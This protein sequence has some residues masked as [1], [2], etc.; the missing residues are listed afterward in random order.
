MI[1]LFNLHNVNSTGDMYII[2]SRYDRINF[3]PLLLIRD[4]FIGSIVL[5]IYNV[6]VYYYSDL[7]GHCDNYVPAN[8]LV[9]PSEIMPE[10]YLLP[11]YALI[12]AI[13][14][15]VLG[16]IMMVLFLVCLTNLSPIVSV[17]SYPNINML[18]QSLL[19]ILLLDL[20][21]ASE[22]CLYINHY[23]CMYLLLILSIL[24]LLQHHI[25][26]SNNNVSTY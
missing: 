5:I 10:F 17:R 1:H 26:I 25:F 15:K 9:T 19:F 11:F 4:L 18:Y 6:F 8:P 14:H 12:R 24:S 23:S 7:F 21:I 20:V 3:Y 22:L 2:G 13:P 16:I